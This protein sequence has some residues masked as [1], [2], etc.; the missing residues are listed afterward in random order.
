[1]T[2]KH[3]VHNKLVIWNE[4]HNLKFILKC[5]NGVFVQLAVVQEVNGL[6]FDLSA[7]R[8]CSMMTQQTWAE[9]YDR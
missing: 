1:M 9:R 7:T 3:T 8:D 2:T 4:R 5:W 6:Q